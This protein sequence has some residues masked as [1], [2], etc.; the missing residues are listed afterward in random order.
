M[1]KYFVIVLSSSTPKSERRK[2]GATIVPA[3]QRRECQAD[4][5]SFFVS[6]S[7]VLTGC[8]FVR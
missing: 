3:S 8:L 6:L 4:G 5:A 1:R 2:D 7:E